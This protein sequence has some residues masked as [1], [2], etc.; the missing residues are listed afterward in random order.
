MLKEQALAFVQCSAHIA[1]WWDILPLIQFTR[2]THMQVSAS[3]LCETTILFTVSR[4]AKG[5]VNEDWI[6]SPWQC[7][8]LRKLEFSRHL[9]PCVGKRV[10]VL[11]LLCDAFFHQLSTKRSPAL[12]ILFTV[13]IF[14][15]SQ[16]NEECLLGNVAIWK[17][18]S[19][20]DTSNLVSGRLLVAVAA[21]SAKPRHV[22]FPTICLSSA[23]TICQ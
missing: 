6:V 10:F 9:K 19:F 1:N 2:K 12:K 16:V 11:M 21:S 3:D 23:A 7:W 13:P 4:F 20:P 15:K 8:K 5:Q 18:W 14:A 17:S 22:V